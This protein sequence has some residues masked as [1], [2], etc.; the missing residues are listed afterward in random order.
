VGARRWHIARAEYHKEV[1]E[2]L[3]H[4]TDYEDWSLVALYYSALHFVDSIL[5]DD[6][7]LPKDER[8]PRKHS[9]L[10]P[11]QR[12]RNQL[13]ADRLSVIR[14]DYRSLEDLSRRTRYDAQKLQQDAATAYDL[15]L[16]QWQHIEQYARMMH[17]TRTVIPTDAP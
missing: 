5:A 12:G 2:H 9:G 15:A 7:D 13:V 16:P 17:M 11:G 1:A 8:H 6:P 4:Q 14:A 10:E 3:R